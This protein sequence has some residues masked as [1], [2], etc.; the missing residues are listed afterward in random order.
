MLN[1]RCSRLPLATLCPA[2]VVPPETKIERDDYD[3]RCGTARHTC[4]TDYVAG[5]AWDAHAAAAE[6]RV[7]VDEVLPVVLAG[8]ECWKAVR[9]HFPQP[10]VEQDMA[11]AHEGAVLRGRAD[12]L[13]VFGLP[14][15]HIADFKTG[16]LDSD[17]DAQLRGYAF[18]AC[19]THEVQLAR[20]CLIRPRA[21]TADWFEWTRE[22]LRGWF[23]DLRA[24][25]EAGDYRPGE[26]CGYCPRSLECPARRQQVGFIVEA[27]LADCRFAEGVGLPRPADYGEICGRVY[28]QVRVLEGLCDMARDA[29]R[30]EVRLAGGQMAIGDGR[31]L[32]LSQQERREIVYKA[33]A[34]IL[35]EAIGDDTLGDLLKVSKTAVEKAVMANAPKGCKG[36]AAKELMGRLESAGAINVTT[37]ERLEARRRLPQLENKNDGNATEQI[38]AAAS[39]SAAT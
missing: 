31:E 33:G 21:G 2:S 18:L 4:L 1:L 22:E 30:A 29:L 19:E 35:A 10:M 27:M 12:V 39:A 16:R 11:Y 7:A 14:A 37:V 32:V 23:G 20:A 34:Q 9:E 36:K 28:D 15:V 25:L 38:T 17:Y 24:R 5:R 13:S 8:I 3:A 26:H 6:Q